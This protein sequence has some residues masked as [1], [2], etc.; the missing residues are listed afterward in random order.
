MYRPKP[1]IKKHPE[2]RWNRP[3]RIFFGFGACHI[4]AGVWLEN[5]PLPDF[6]AEWIVPDDGFSGTHFFVTDDT[7]AFDFHGYSLRQ[8]LLDHIRKGWSARYPGWNATIQPVDFPLLDTAT[9]NARKHLGPDQ[10]FGDP[11]PCA[12]RFIDR[13]DHP[14]AAR[15]ARSG[16]LP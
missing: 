14:A 4:L 3:D 15:H 10:Y 8:N 11:L 9:M 13:F 2:R 12:R 7:V 6:H 16:S 5:P 1:G